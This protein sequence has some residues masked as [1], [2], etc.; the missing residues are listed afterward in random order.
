MER[1]RR[2]LNVYHGDVPPVALLQQNLLYEVQVVRWAKFNFYALDF[3]DLRKK[4]IHA[5][6]NLV[7]EFPARKNLFYLAM[8]SRYTCRM[9]VPLRVL[10]EL[11]RNIYTFTAPYF[12][13]HYTLDQAEITR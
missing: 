2:A 10:H 9:Q 1:V 12:T 13:F 7:F 8:R 5:P 11:T 3:G 4:A 6:V